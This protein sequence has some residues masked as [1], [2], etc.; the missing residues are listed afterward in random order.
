M[1]LISQLTLSLF[2]GSVHSIIWYLLEAVAFLAVSIVAFRYQRYRGPRKLHPLVRVALVLCFC[3]SWMLLIALSAYK[4][5]SVPVALR[6]NE[7]RWERISDLVA[8]PL[9]QVFLT[10][11]QF[12]DDT[13]PNMVDSYNAGGFQDLLRYVEQAISQRILS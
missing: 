4:C 2:R 12:L 9:R 13:L 8:F 7:L 6:E 3:S 10:L 11:H 1:A 5:G